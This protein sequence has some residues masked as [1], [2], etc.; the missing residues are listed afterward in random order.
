MMLEGSR[1]VLCSSQSPHVRAL[2]QVALES[3]R[4]QGQGQINPLHA[5]IGRPGLGTCGSLG[6]GQPQAGLRSG[7]TPLSRKEGL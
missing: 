7:P 1:A 3:A 2:R 5:P 4:V 6:E